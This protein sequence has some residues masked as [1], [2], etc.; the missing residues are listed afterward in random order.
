[1]MLLPIVPF[2]CLDCYERLWYL[3]LSWVAL[4]R[5]AVLLSAIALA[6][7]LVPML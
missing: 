6:V 5:S 7:R 2:R 3:E 4:G 1:M